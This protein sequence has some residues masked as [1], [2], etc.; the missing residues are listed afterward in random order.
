MTK[1]TKEE[2][3]EIRK[4][5]YS[6]YQESI[7]D[8]HMA[9]YDWFEAHRNFQIEAKRAL[10]DVGWNLSDEYKVEPIYE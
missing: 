7:E 8:G 1:V 2:A 3:E 10:N 4:R 6:K 9:P 5:I